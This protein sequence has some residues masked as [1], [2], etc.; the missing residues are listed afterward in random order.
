MLVTIRY[1][2]QLAWTI[3]HVQE[4]AGHIYRTGQLVIGGLTLALGRELIG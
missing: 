4:V 3:A 1:P 2:P